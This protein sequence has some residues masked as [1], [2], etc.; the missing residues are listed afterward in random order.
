MR[1]IKWKSTTSK[2]V[3]SFDVGRYQGFWAV[4]LRVGE[5]V[6]AYYWGK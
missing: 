1:F 2:L 6:Y 5:T 4:T 3:F